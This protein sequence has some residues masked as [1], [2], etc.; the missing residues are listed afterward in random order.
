MVALNKSSGDVVWKAAIDGNNTAAYSSPIIARAGKV[1]E[2]VTFLHGALVGV[3]AAKG[4]LLWRYEHSANGTA[5]IPTAVYKDGYI[6]SATGYG[7]GGGLVRLNGK[8]ASEV[9]FQN[10]AVNQIGGFVLVGKHLYG[11]NDQSLLCLEFKTGD[12]V[13]QNRSV[14]KGAVT[15]ADGLLFVRS[16]HGPIALVAASP[17]GYK[18]LGE[19]KQPERSN[20]PAWPYPVVANGRLYIRDQGLLLAFDVKE[21]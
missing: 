8:G 13:W 16:E 9:Y 3:D 12:I 11:T 5:N 10:K 20:E 19:F 1:K 17:A 21:K 18:E 4:K 6:F 2:Y 14:G 15:A 7:T